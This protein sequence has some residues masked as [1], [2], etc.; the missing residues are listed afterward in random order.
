MVLSSSKDRYLRNSFLPLLSGNVSE[1]VEKIDLEKWKEALTILIINNCKPGLFIDFAERLEE[2]SLYSA[3][4]AC[5][6]YAGSSDRVL[7]SWIKQFKNSIDNGVAYESAVFNLF[8]RSLLYAESLKFFDSEYLESITFEYL[9]MLFKQGLNKEGLE[10]IKYLK[11]PKYY[12][13]LNMLIEKHLRASNENAKAPWRV[14][15]V[16]PVKTK[17]SPKMKEAYLNEPVTQHKNSAFPK[18]APSQEHVRS[19]MPVT[20]PEPKRGAFPEPPKTIFQ[21]KSLSDPKKSPFPSSKE[22]IPI[23]PKKNPFGDLREPVHNLRNTDS[24]G[25]IGMPKA[26]TQEK[27]ISPPPPPPIKQTEVKKSEISPTNPPV[28]KKHEISNIEPP[29]ISKATEPPIAQFRS[30]VLR[31]EP[32]KEVYKQESVKALPQG[33][34]EAKKKEVTPP[35]VPKTVPPPKIPTLIP[36]RPTAKTVSA[37]EGIDLSGI[38]QNLLPLAQKW[39]MAINDGSLSSNP[40]ILKDV[41]T[42]MQEFF[43][44]LRNQEFNEMT[45]NLIFELTEAFSNGDIATVNKTHLELT[46][47][48]WTE[49]GNWLTAMKRIFQAKQTARGK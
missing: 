9:T 25:P 22:P 39:E 33:L 45:M 37:S 38:P 26:V 43:N 10:I 12:L 21:E 14:L 48:T 6:I 7:K 47:K 32:V 17:A 16:M 36:N 1:L 20:V 42:K 27:I 46:N 28:F 44:K 2:H 5:Y 41:E 30:E 18:S 8:F 3:A 19:A 31:Q 34:E 11:S 40:R 13:P 4:Q 15:N 24:K 49:N 29:P 23:E 35:A